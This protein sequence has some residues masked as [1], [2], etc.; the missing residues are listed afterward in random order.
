MQKRATADA[1]AAL[2][3]TASPPHDP[4][5]R[6]RTSQ[7]AGYDEEIRGILRGERQISVRSR[8][9]PRLDLKSPGRTAGGASRRHASPRHEERSPERLLAR[10]GEHAEL[11]GAEPVELVDELRDLV[12]RGDAIAQARRVLEAQVAREARELGAEPREDRRDVVA[13]EVAERAG[14]ELR[15]ALAR[16]RAEAS[17]R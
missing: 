11:L 13:V 4:E 2:P 5:L 9:Q 14:R 12:E 15:P 10:G 16:D 6:R 3:S 1:A 17:R 7:K 8:G